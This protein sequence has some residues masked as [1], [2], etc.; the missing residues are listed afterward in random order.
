[1]LKRPQY[2]AIV[3]VVL[4]ALAL[5]GQSERVTSRIRLAVG[6]LFLPLFGV[7]NSAQAL[8]DRGTASILPRAELLR[9]MD[10]LQLENRRLRLQG[11]QWEEAARENARLREALLLPRQV[12]WR[13]RM[14]RVVGRDPAN[15]WKNVRINLGSRDGITNNMPVIAA[16]GL[17]GRVSE[18]GYTHSSVVLL[19]DPA[20]RVSVLVEETR[21]HGVIAPSDAGA[22]DN[23]I[24]DLKF[25]SRNSILKPGQRVVTSGL[26]NL[27]PKGIVVGQIADARSVQFGLYTEARVSLAARLNTLEEVWVIAQ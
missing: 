12:P 15:W 22:V 19:G 27:F 6:G 11:I 13:L 26:G 7:A 2:I 24:V 25:L 9:Q 20:C 3:L 21:D 23:T 14:A 10:E 17:V 5:L 16:E 4:L 8:V 18:T 1:M